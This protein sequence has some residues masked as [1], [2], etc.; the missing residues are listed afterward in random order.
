MLALESRRLRRRLAQAFPTGSRAESPALVHGLA[1]DMIMPLVDKTRSHAI[2]IDASRE[3]SVDAM[4]GIG[5]EANV[6]P[7]V[8]S[9]QAL[10]TLV[11]NA[12]GGLRRE[13]S[14]RGTSAALD[15]AL[16]TAESLLGQARIDTSPVRG[17][18][19]PLLLESAR[20]AGS[21]R[22]HHTVRQ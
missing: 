7:V 1:V 5:A 18:I 15:W 19:G 6:K 3:L 8:D 22:L 21:E 13:P 16:R 14:S 10:L 9:I 2:G 12:I 20:P 17:W 11:N 4:A